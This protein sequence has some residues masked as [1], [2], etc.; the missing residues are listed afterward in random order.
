VPGSPEVS[1]SSL[2]SKR[3]AV[4]GA[5]YHGLR[6]S[7]EKLAANKVEGRGYDDGTE[8]RANATTKLEAQ[9]V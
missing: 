9:A 5:L 7:V 1:S 2:S 8:Q 3:H 4:V 6:E